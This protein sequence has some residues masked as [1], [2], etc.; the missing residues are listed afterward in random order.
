MAKYLIQDIIPKERHRN[1]EGARRVAIKTPHARS[2]KHALLVP[3]ENEDVL[4]AAHANAPRHH[5]A[6]SDAP[7][8]EKNP[9]NILASLA[10]E[11]SLVESPHATTQS[12]NEQAP[13]SI[14]ASTTQRLNGGHAFAGVREGGGS[15]FKN[16][17]PWLLGSVV[18]GVATVVILNFLGGAVVRVSPKINSTPVDLKMS[19]LK[20]P[21]DAELAFSVMKVALEE[22]SEVPA[23]GEKALTAKAKG[24]IIIY[25]TQTTVQRLI[26]NTRFQSPLGKI[27][28][29]ADS[30]DIPKAKAPSG[31]SG[32]LVP[33]SIE[34]TIYADEAGPDYNSE[35]TDFTVPGLKG[36]PVFEKVY[37]RGKGP[38]TGGASGTIKSVSDLDMKNAGEALR[39]QLETKLR[40]KARGDLA[41][42]QISFDEGIVVELKQPTLSKAAAS[43]ADRAVVSLSG[44]LSMVTFDRQALTAAIVKNSVQSYRG[45][46]VTIPNIE[47]LDFRI[48]GPATPLLWDAEKLDFS[49]KGVPNLVWSINESDIK[50]AL[51]GA[52]KQSFN[53]IMAQFPTIELARATISPA[54]KRSFPKNEADITIQVDSPSTE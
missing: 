10:S 24:Q 53:A 39:I 4:H 9:R 41:L 25:N 49:L 15:F 47:S 18:L 31:T 16:W 3:E 13:S 23:T 50:K 17:T 26:K 1:T 30:V 29:I 38:I 27:Y 6:T 11:D 19:A 48:L 34:A 40:A 32:K 52:P 33:G 5:A 37:A 2:P 35:A 8:L 51:L 43:S 46:V 22:T 54:W 42:S 20:N 14:D 28:R 12:F 21:A 45:E 44:V 36:S 7:E